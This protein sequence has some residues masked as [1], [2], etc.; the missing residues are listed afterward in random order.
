MGTFLFLF[1]FMNFK[2]RNVP[3]FF[4]GGRA[5]KGPPPVTED[6]PSG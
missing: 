4:P 2:N 3:I 1:S 6:G 5:K